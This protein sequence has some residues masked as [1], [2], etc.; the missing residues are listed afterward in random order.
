MSAESA[1]A[2]FD[3]PKYKAASG[4]GG[5]NP[6]PFHQRARRLRTCTGGPSCGQAVLSSRVTSR[7]PESTDVVRIGDYRWTGDDFCGATRPLPST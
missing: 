1:E 7:R 6:L 2:I 5:H 3:D 4:G